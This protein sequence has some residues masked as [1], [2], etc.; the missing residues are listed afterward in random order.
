MY[1]RLTLKSICYM[2]RLFL[3]FITYLT[4]LN[5]FA[6]S[7][8][9]KNTSDSLWTIWKDE[10]L[11]DQQRVKALMTF[12][13]KG[14]LRSNP[15][16]AYYYY[17]LAYEMAN[18]ANL[19]REKA[20]ILNSQGIAL[21]SLGNY[22][23]AIDHYKRSLTILQNLGLEKESAVL[24]S[25]ISYL[26]RNLGEYSKALE[27]GFISLSTHKKPVFREENRFICNSSDIV[28]DP[29]QRFV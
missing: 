20:V 26:Y 28:I 8:L 18:E 27:F 1:F 22:Y 16:S 10:T 29:D 25:N 11:S 24:Q 15:D 4:G 6:Q 17:T 14:Y 9:P 23:S 13:S 21:N 7:T 5:S 3:I 12:T 2:A 19:E